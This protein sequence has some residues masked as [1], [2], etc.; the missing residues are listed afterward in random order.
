MTGQINL[1]KTRESQPAFS[2]CFPKLIIFSFVA[3]CC[4]SNDIQ[5]LQ[6]LCLEC[7][8]KRDNNI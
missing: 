8:R 6:L 1:S 3:R 4:G 7:H 2:A 5:N